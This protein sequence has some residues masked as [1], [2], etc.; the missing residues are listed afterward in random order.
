MKT[1]AAGMA[2][3]VA[4]A[5]VAGAAGQQP[6]WAPAPTR[7]HVLI[8]VS[9]TWTAD[10]ENAQQ[11]LTINGAL[12]RKAPDAE[13]VRSL[14]GPADAPAFVKA[15][16]APGAFP[17]AV[18]RDVKDFQS[19]RLSV[20]FK[21]V[22]GATDQTAGIMFNLKPDGTYTY[23]RYNTKDGNVA[24][25][26]FENGERAV[27]KHGEVH[28]QLPKGEWHTLT[29]VIAGATV[30]ASANSRLAASHTLEV[31]VSGRLGVWT[32]ADSVTSFRDFL[33]AGA[34]HSIR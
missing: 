21:L 32:K 23:A 3:V 26:K 4:S 5:I 29:V 14:F 1:M 25:W 28:E 11:I 9:G 12:P 18:V 2:I 13:A 7:P 8:P 20:R 30:T 10:Y 22:D 33:V 19:G 15:L 34:H 16:E 24:I 31:P 6:A 17:L 27:L